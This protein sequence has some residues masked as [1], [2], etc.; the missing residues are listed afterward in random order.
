[1]TLSANELIIPKYFWIFIAQYI[2]M[3]VKLGDKTI[4]YEIQFPI[5][6]GLAK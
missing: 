2:I 6:W 3:K 4:F 5:K 1:V